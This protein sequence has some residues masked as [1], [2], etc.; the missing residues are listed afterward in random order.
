MI[1]K[2]LRT[3]FLSLALLLGILSIFPPVVAKAQFDPL[4]ANCGTQ[5][6]EIGGC[7]DLCNEQ[8]DN[9]VACTENELGKGTENPV[10]TTTQNVV[11]LLSLATAAI[12]VVVIIIAGITMTLSQGDAGKVKSSRDAIIYAAVGLVVAALARAIVFFIVNRTR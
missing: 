11:N 10:T 4:N 6:N 7:I 12:A 9:S 1:K 5:G 3:S 2:Y 8:T